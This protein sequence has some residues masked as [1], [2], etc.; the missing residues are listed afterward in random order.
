MIQAAAEKHASIVQ[1]DMQKGSRLA[2]IRLKA[3]TARQLVE[4]L[5]REGGLVIN[6]VPVTNIRPL[7]GEEELLYWILSAETQKREASKFDHESEMIA[8]VTGAKSQK[9]RKGKININSLRKGRKPTY[10]KVRVNLRNKNPSS[11]KLNANKKRIRDENEDVVSKKNKSP[12]KKQ[13]MTA[14]KTDQAFNGILDVLQGLSV[15]K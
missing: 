4:M 5:L 6:H 11:D 8:L 12:A 2:Y 1:V 14:E 9:K 3:V 15:K 7:V 10:T 13:K